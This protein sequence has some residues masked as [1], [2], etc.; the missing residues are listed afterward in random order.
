MNSIDTFMWSSFLSPGKWTGQTEWFLFLQQFFNNVL[1]LELRNLHEH[2]KSYF[3]RSIP[4][5]LYEK[6]H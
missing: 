1:F 5:M 3:L 6:F 2:Q 4:S